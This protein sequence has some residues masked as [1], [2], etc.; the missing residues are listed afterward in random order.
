MASTHGIGIEKG[1]R[2]TVFVPQARLLSAEEVRALPREKREAAEGSGAAGVW[3]EVVC[4]DG[5]CL[6]EADRVSIPIRAEMHKGRKG[7]W[8]NL[9]CPEDACEVTGGSYLA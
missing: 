3:M 8:L 1:S 9:F 4:P 5:A 2:L 6:E 7:I